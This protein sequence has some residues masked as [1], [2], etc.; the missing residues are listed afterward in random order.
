[1]TFDANPQ[2]FLTKLQVPSFA[3]LR[4]TF[5]VIQGNS[6]TLSLEIPWIPDIVEY[7]VYS[8][9]SN[10]LV[11]K[12]NS[13][14]LKTDQRYNQI[15]LLHHI[16]PEDTCTSGD[17]LYNFNIMS[18]DRSR[19][20]T[21]QVHLK[22]ISR[23]PD[24]SIQLL[25][26]VRTLLSDDSTPIRGQ[27]FTDLE[28]LEYLNLAMMEV[29][30][31]PTLTRFTINTADPVFGFLLVLGAEYHALRSLYNRESR[32]VF[33]FNDDGISVDISIRGEKYMNMINHLSGTYTQMKAELK[34]HYRPYGRAHNSEYVNLSIRN[35]RPFMIAALNSF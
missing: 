32:D 33:S 10:Q 28:L 30:G 3:T 15:F 26:T 34:K 18:T 13:I 11:S 17:F 22:V 23:L 27:V 21:K 24:K 9:C 12:A 2:N 4:N 20:F 8:E 7:D 14:E 19:V 16:K 25:T 29:N 6:V 5:P 31:T 1:M 35:L